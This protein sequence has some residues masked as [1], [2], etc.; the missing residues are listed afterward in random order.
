M[1]AKTRIME[2]KYDAMEALA[3]ALD[4][5]RKLA[6]LPFSRV[7]GMLALD[8]EDLDRMLT[9]E[10]GLDGDDLLLWLRD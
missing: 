3:E 10:L 8:S 4:R 2:K 9:D 1:F 7:C 6:R 5:N